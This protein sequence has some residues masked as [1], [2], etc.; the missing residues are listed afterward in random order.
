[1]NLVTSSTKLQRLL[2]VP[3]L[4]ARINTIFADIF[5]PC[6]YGKPGKKNEQVGRPRLLDHG[7]PPH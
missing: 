5:I 6:R 1:M 4:N 7:L 3:Q 2:T